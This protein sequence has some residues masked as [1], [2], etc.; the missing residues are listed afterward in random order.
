MAYILRNKIVK[1]EAIPKHSIAL[2]A[3]TFLLST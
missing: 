3:Y 2:F 1:I